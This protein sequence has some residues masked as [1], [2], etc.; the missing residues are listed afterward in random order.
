LGLFGLKQIKRN[1]VP[2]KI[3]EFRNCL[4]NSAERRV[5][6]DGKY[7]ELTPRT[8]D[9]LQLLVEKSGE[10]VT[11]DEILGKVWNGSFVEEGNL[12]V[13]VSK[14]RRLL[15]DNKAEHF[16]ETVQGS[17][18]RFV[19]PVKSVNA[20]E[21]L[22]HLPSN[23][24]TQ[25][26]RTSS[27]FVFDSIAVMPLR[28]ESN[29]P[30]ID[31]LADG[32]TESFINSLSRIPDLK[33]IAR[34]TV[35]RYK[36]KEVDPKEVGETLGIVAVLTGRIKV[37]KD[38][39]MISIGLIR[40]ADGSQLWGTQFNQPFSDI[41]KIQEEITL[42][43]SEKLRSE[44]KG[45]VRTSQNKPFTQDSE[46]YRL[47]LKGKY[48]YSKHTLGDFNK[49]IKCFQKSV[50]YDPA[51]VHSYAQIIE[52]Y[53]S[54]YAFDHISYKDFSIKTAPFIEVIS[55]LEQ[56]IDVVQVMY[57]KFKMFS[58]WDFVEPEKHLRLALTINPNSLI[59][60]IRYSIFL[61]WTGRFSEALNE[62]HKVMELDPLSLSTYKR[63]GRLFYAMGQYENALIYL[64]DALEME[65]SDYEA[66]TLLGAVL[67]EIGDYRGA[68]DSFQKSLSI[69]SN[70]E[71]VSMIG[72]IYALEGKRKI[73]KQ[74]IE[75]LESQS[76]DDCKHSI[77]L[78]RIYVALGEKKT[79][80]EY[81]D[82]AFTLHECDLVGL[83]F[84]PKWRTIR[85][86]SRFKEL[87]NKVGL[88]IN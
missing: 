72:Y 77:K 29:N 23:N 53:L 18:Y 21:W 74:M 26:V 64:N 3:Y 17:G 45:V 12:P 87:M 48:F 78:A 11:K 4:L 25:P 58:D 65:P 6:R 54:L 10:I 39:L 22:K 38:R 68:L 69:H 56:S 2:M 44:I 7:L 60:H 1:L 82:Q 62:L 32:L 66:L 70:V 36:N 80:Y 16:I 81:L 31:Y 63:M 55:T 27:R 30:E 47:Y 14:L 76:K 51:N 35:F 73:A 42:A 28:N 34:D 61:I 43:V 49:A 59:A 84:D 19:S 57:S 88:P 71:T 79:T 75:Q 8:F 83:T 46:S 24:G 85:N 40:V 50:S 67:T 9:V 20:N 13:H 33:V 86:E 41:V 5:I 15:N 37:V 52:C